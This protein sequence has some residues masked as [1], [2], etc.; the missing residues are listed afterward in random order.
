MKYTISILIFLLIMMAEP[1]NAQDF[2]LND[3]TPE[4]ECA[5]EELDRT[6]VYNNTL[7]LP[8]NGKKHMVRLKWHIVG[9]TS[10]DVSID[11]DT[12]QTY[13][14]QANDAYRGIGI[15]FVADPVI[16]YII[17][18][19]W[20]KNG[21][22]YD[23]LRATG[24]LDGAMNVYWSSNLLPAGL[25]GVGS[26]V[27][28]SPQGICM[29][30]TCFNKSDV[31]GVFVHETGH[32]FNLLH[33]HTWECPEAARC[34]TQGDRVCDTPPSP[35]LGHDVCVDSSTCLLYE[36]A[37]K[38]CYTTNNE[39]CNETVYDDMHIN[40][41]NYM[42]YTTLPCLQEFTQGQRDRIYSTYIKLRPELHNVPIPHCIGDLNG[43]G[44]V[45]IAD[46]LLILDAWGGVEGD[47]DGDANT[48]INDFLILINTWRH[49]E[50][51]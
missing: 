32:F 50:Q 46:V 5:L 17:N 15:Q 27:W 10:G 42:S 16:H 11:T 22:W 34:E 40:T 39:D 26:F 20:W 47:L 33:T 13:L 51:S 38:A 19:D 49:C 35:R 2:C 24:S 31:G 14:H 41:V 21:V 6:G 25:C 8:S 43:D 23:T 28:V 1:S 48:D 36:D 44:M 7:E 18:D 4:D 9:N 12:L 30:T 3:I 29:S 37:N 45:H